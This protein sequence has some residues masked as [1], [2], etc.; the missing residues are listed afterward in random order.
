MASAAQDRPAHDRLPRLVAKQLGL[1][2][3]IAYYSRETRDFEALGLAEFWRAYVAWRCAPLGRVGPAT[4]TAVLYNFAPAMVG[5]A[6]P[7][8]WDTTTPEAVLA[9]RDD[10]MGRALDRAFVGFADE[11]AVE[12]ATELALDGIERGG[13]PAGRALFAAHLD[14]ALPSTPRLALWHACTLWREYR[15]DSH[16]I[17][18]AAA[19]IDGVEAHVLLAARGVGNAATIEQIRGWTAE[20]WAAAID[21]LAGRGLVTEA[22]ESTEDGLQLR[23]DIE[24]HTDELSAGPRNALGEDGVARLMELTEPIAA[25]FVEVGA[26]A[27]RWP[28]PKPVARGDR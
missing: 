3:N 7:S 15:G 5:D 25:H 12:A 20:E 16:N 11:A 4:A 27:G 22:G 19:G 17:A 18:L 1:I 8:A 13:D 2:H 10:C 6:L 28:P 14:L 9:L 23:R 21:R 24:A 26:V